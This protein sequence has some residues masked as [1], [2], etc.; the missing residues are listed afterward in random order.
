[1]ATN[2]AAEPQAGISATPVKLLNVGAGGVNNGIPVDP[3][4]DRIVIRIPGWHQ[5]FA[6]VTFQKEDSDNQDNYHIFL[7]RNGQNTGYG[8]ARNLKTGVTDLGS[9]SLFALLDLNAND[10]LELYIWTDAETGTIT[11]VD[12]QFV[13]VSV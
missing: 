9:G 2:N 7:Y 6:Q 3:A 4:N 11:V 13:V 1:M 8:F 12:A 10:V 5:V